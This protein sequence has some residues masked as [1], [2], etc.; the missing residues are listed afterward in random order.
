[1]KITECFCKVIYQFRSTADGKIHVETRDF[2]HYEHALQCVRDQERK[3]GTLFIR[4]IH[5]AEWG[6]EQKMKPF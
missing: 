5:K 2:D 6:T 4:L 3:K 1:M